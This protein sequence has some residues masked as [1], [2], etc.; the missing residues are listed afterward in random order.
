MLGVGMAVAARPQMM[1]MDEPAAGL[2]PVETIEMGRLIAR[3][4]TELGITVVL[5]E[6]DMKMVMSLCDRI[7]VLNYGQVMKIGTSEEVRSDPAVIEAYLGA[8]DAS[9]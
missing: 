5:V 3:L 8:E 1:L 9:A 4:R 2:N 6:H 7:L